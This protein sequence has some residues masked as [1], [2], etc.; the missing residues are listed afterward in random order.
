[1][2]CLGAKRP[3]KLTGPSNCSRRCSVLPSAPLLH[4]SITSGK[5]EPSNPRNMRV[6]L[7]GAMPLLLPP[8]LSPFPKCPG[9]ALHS[10][11]AAKGLRLLRHNKPHHCLSLR[12]HSNLSILDTITFC[13]NY[14]I[15]TA[16]RIRN[17][18]R[19]HRTIPPLPRF[20]LRAQE[21]IISSYFPAVR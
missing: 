12:A 16:L 15:T 20:V 2:A 17:D 11:Y 1:M 4:Q 10:S 6:L 19:S 7:P 18:P 9:P 13:H 5:T 8:P 3:K 14:C 21:G